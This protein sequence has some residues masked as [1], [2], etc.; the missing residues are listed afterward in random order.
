MWQGL[1]RKAGLQLTRQ[2]SPGWL[3][4]WSSY[5]S[6]PHSGTHSYVMTH[7]TQL[8]NA[9]VLFVYYSFYSVMHAKRDTYQLAV[10]PVLECL[11]ENWEWKW[12]CENN[13]FFFS[14]YTSCWYTLFYLGCNKWRWPGGAG[15]PVIPVWGLPHVG[16][17]PELQSETVKKQTRIKKDSWT[18]PSEGYCSKDCKFPLTTSGL[19]FLKWDHKLS[20]YVVVARSGL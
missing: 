4:W 13:S 3:S 7:Y 20:C 14:L 11:K 6:L 18:Q 17:Q 8:E 9:L 12:Q 16:G 5:P 1:L 10:S 19:W 2:S 15:L